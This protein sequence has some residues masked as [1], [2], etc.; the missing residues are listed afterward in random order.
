MSIAKILKQ[1]ISALHIDLSF[2]EEI[3]DLPKGELVSDK[4]DTE[5]IKKVYNE[6]CNIFNI[7]LPKLNDLGWS[8]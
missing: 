1:K 7:K 6:L 2:F 8:D 3:T 5:T 4:W